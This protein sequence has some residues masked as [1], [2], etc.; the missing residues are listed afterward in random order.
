MNSVIDGPWCIGGDFNV[1][2]DPDEN[3]GGRPYTIHKSLDF[4]NYMDSCEAI[5][6]GYNGSAFTWSNNIRP[7][8][9]I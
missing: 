1:I 8:K 6:L 2:M 9:R 4:I 5:D 7:R 3:L